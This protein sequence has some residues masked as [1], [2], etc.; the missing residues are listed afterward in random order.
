MIDQRGIT[1]LAVLLGVI[2][3]FLAT[4]SF[5]QRSGEEVLAS[6]GV[7]VLGI[8]QWKTTDPNT[9]GGGSYYYLGVEYFVGDS[10]LTKEFSVTH[11]AYVSHPF[12]SQVEV[13]YDPQNPKH[14]RLVGDLN[15][16]ASWKTLLIGIGAVVGSFAAGIWARSV[17]N[18]DKNDIPD[19][20]EAIARAKRGS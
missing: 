14:A 7:R 13:V 17:A 3:L 15:N 11:R 1:L 9:R 20:D 5:Y 6:R 8:V 10:R 2:G 4:F 16:A 18:R 12:R 19:L